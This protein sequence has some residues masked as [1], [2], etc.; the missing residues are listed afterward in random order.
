M[1]KY[2]QRPFYF[3]LHR[4]NRTCFWNE[5]FKKIIY[6]R[7][8][9]KAV[10]KPNTKIFITGDN[11]FFPRAVIISKVSSLLVKCITFLSAFKTSFNCESWKSCWRLMENHS[12]WRVCKTVI[13]A[14]E[15]KVW[16]YLALFTTEV[17]TYY[18]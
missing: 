16:K 15:S 7:F 17:F 13:K 1:V 11:N 18:N 8:K 9:R 5:L 6:L 4:R 3:W 14:K 12:R 10:I 2:S